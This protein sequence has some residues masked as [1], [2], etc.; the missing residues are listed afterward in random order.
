MPET[1]QELNVESMVFLDEFYLLIGT[2]IA[3]YD[4]TQFLY[5]CKKKD[6][7]DI[8]KLHDKTYF[9]DTT[10]SLGENFLISMGKDQE[11]ESK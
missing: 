8:F 11:E 9:L 5:N 1:I 10:K 3:S 7:K 4:Q 2:H 6:I